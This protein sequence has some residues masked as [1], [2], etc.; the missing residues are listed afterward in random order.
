MKH[1]KK[2]AFCLCMMTMTFGMVSAQA[3]LQQK[4][5]GSDYIKAVAVSTRYASKRPTPEERLFRSN[6]IEEKIRQV[7]KLLKHSP[8]LAWMFENCFPNTLDTTVHY[9]EDSDGTSVL[10]VYLQTAQAEF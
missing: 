1:L 2:R 3:P 6:V 4:E 5:F 9:T 10:G 8:Y 7:K